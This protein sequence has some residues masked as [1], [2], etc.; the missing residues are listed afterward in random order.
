MKKILIALDYNSLADKVAE[1]GFAIANAMNAEIILVHVIADPVYYNM[2][3]FNIMGY[4]SGFIPDVISDDNVI[5]KE[6]ELFLAATVK[7]LN[8]GK[9]KTFVL[10][11]D[12]EDAILKFSEEQKVD[13]IV[14]GS[15]N[16]KGIDRFVIPDVAVHILKHSKIPMLTIP[17][18]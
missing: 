18:K 16:H 2:P 8:D 10:D 5:K 1:T 9:I 15:H 14:L 17:T 12:V 4:E 6:A 13:L 11:G 3:Y 7:H